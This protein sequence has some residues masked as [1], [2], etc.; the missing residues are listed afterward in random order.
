MLVKMVQLGYLRAETKWQ[1]KLLRD[2]EKK[3]ID[4]INAILYRFGHSLTFCSKLT[5]RKLKQNKFYLPDIGEDGAVW[6]S[7]GRNRVAT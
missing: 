1:R 2:C 3:K 7:E 5:L 4:K 6:I